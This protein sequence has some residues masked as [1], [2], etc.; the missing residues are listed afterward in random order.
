MAQDKQN[1]GTAGKEMASK[2]TASKETASK[3][4]GEG[5]YDAARRYEEK[6]RDHVEHHDVA[7]EARDAEPSSQG[8]EREMEQAEER[9]KRRAK[10]ED[11][12]LEHPENIEVDTGKPTGSGTGR[13]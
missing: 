7:K 5:D 12:L 8:E 9:G 1:P 3:V 10:E 2:K 4:Q 11:T 13:K 6:L